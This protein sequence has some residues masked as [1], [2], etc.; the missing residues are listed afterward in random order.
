MEGLEGFEEFLVSGF[1]VCVETRYTASVFSK[2][3]GLEVLLV[4][5]LKV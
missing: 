4:S 3:L 2:V 1:R 5:G